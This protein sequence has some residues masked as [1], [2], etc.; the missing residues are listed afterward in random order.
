MTIVSLFITWPFNLNRAKKDFFPG[1]SERFL[2]C[3]HHQGRHSSSH[4]RTPAFS[5]LTAF[6]ILRVSEERRSSGAGSVHQHGNF[7][8]EFKTVEERR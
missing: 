8:A 3:E 2:T 1:L 7:Q 4:G 5:S 6:Y